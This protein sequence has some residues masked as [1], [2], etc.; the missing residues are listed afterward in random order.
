MFARHYQYPVLDVN[1]A[2]SEALP[3]RMWDALVTLMD[4]THPIEEIISTLLLDGFSL[5]D[6]SSALTKL[7]QEGALREAS[8]SALGLLAHD[9]LQWYAHHLELF[10]AFQPSGNTGWPPLPK[11]GLSALSTLKQARVCLIGEGDMLSWLSLM[12]AQW[13][14]GNIMI[15]HLHNDLSKHFTHLIESVN[16]FVK[17]DFIYLKD[18][19]LSNVFEQQVPNI[20][21]Y[22]PDQFDMDFCLHINEF[23]VNNS[24]RFIAKRDSGPVIEI[25]PLVIPRQTACFKCYVLRRFAIDEYWIAQEERIKW[26]IPLAVDWLSLEVIKALTQIAQPASYGYLLRF[27]AL[28]G[29]LSRHPVLKLP[30]CPACGVAKPVP[31]RLWQEVD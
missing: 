11:T 28:T 7:E 18:G 17:T 22:C 19:N 10:D 3:D 8:D 26:C 9:E 21:V 31:L 30:R 6:I 23:A 12:L 29:S 20:F 13:G 24:V 27:D 14:V 2:V 15:V 1:Q 25:G 16:P 4:G 5:E